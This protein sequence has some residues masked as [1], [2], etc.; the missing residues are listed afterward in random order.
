LAG[1]CLV[2]AIGLACASGA[3]AAGLADGVWTIR[4]EA[5]L[6]LQSATSRPAS[7]L[8]RLPMELTV[9]VR[10]GKAE[11]QAWGWCEDMPALEHPGRAL[12]AAGDQEKA[13]FEVDLTVRHG[14]FDGFFI[15]GSAR[16]AIELAR[17]GEGWTGRYGLIASDSNNPQTIRGLER[18]YGMGIDPQARGE[19]R[20]RDTMARR[21]TWFLPGGQV[22]GKAIGAVGPLPRRDPG[23]KPPN[24]R[25]HP[26]LFFTKRDVPALRAKAAA[27]QAQPIVVALRE[28]SRKAVER[29]F[30]RDGV[31]GNM[32]AV[33]AAGEGLLFQLTG[34]PIHAQR[35]QEWCLSAMYRVYPDGQGWAHSYS[36][37]GMA[38]AY[39]LCY[40]AWPQEFRDRAYAWLWENATSF[41]AQVDDIDPLQTDRYGFGNDSRSAGVKNSYG[42]SGVFDARG[43]RY[44]AAG[45]L[46]ALAISG[47]PPPI[48]RPIPLDQVAAIAPDRDFMPVPGTPVVPFTS[49]RMSELWLMNGPFRRGLA[50]DPLAS[51]GGCASARP[52]E[53]TKVMHD[54]VAVEF[55]T[56]HPAGTDCC[57]AD[58]PRAGLY[59]RE[60][61]GYWYR[62][63]HPGEALRGKWNAAGGPYETDLTL[64]TILDNDQPRVVMAKPNWNY[65]GTGSR[66]WING[67]E[68]TDG[69]VLRL[70]AGM[71]HVM[72]LVRVTG[73]Y[74][75]QA[76][77]LVEYGPA[78]HADAVRRWEWAQRQMGGRPEGEDEMTQVARMLTRSVLRYAERSIG[79]EASGGW[80][81]RSQREF[82]HGYGRSE[83]SIHSSLLP[84]LLA[85]R[86]LT[87]DNLAATGGLSQ[88]APAALRWRG[89]DR[90]HHELLLLSLGLMPREYQPY[91]AWYLQEEGY[92]IRR[93]YEGVVAL[94]GLDPTV[95][96]RHPGERFALGGYCPGHGL[97]LMPSGWDGA[98]GYLVTVEANTLPMGAPAAAGNFAIMGRGREWIERRDRTF[99]PA[100][101]YTTNVAFGG[102]GIPTGG[103]KVVH[104]ELFKNGGGVVS[105]LVDQ[106][107]WGRPTRPR[108]SEGRAPELGG[109]GQDAQVLDGP[110]PKMSILRSVAVD[111]SRRCG[112]PALVVVADRIRGLSADD[113]KVWHLFISHMGHVGD[114][115]FD[116]VAGKRMFRI[117]QGRATERHPLDDIGA[118]FT[119]A[120]PEKA[121]LSWFNPRV[122]GG[123]QPIVHFW[124]DRKLDRL[125]RDR[126]DQLADPA[127]P[128]AKAVKPPAPGAKERRSD[129]MDALIEDGARRDRQAQR[130]DCTYV[131]VFTLGGGTHPK[132][133]VV[134]GASEPTLRVGAR[135]VV[136]SGD[137]LVL[138]E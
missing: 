37:L 18:A 25:E 131:A 134:E 110:P 94:L 31:D 51:I 58:G 138:R 102:E 7:P 33:W 64:Y 93:P 84:L 56:Y 22:E 50:S 23:F 39:D 103:G 72:C 129:D 86:N 9:T 17:Q 123:L 11:A 111:Y 105:V 135:T 73:G 3:G 116:P 81:I 63:Y 92:R 47:D 29:G 113:E 137:K 114:K 87:G 52:V 34:E 125:E 79:P 117:G 126:R 59:P 122:D 98:K 108:P 109:P 100:D 36:V 8:R 62:D 130:G 119:M 10:E 4:L 96:P 77:H 49:G 71:Y 61:G 27:P 15:G 1:G 45:A 101:A 133:E 121:E 19:E 53:G 67:R 124:M 24:P 120:L 90:T 6:P 41:A 26:R 70:S 66:M 106:F 60:C 128:A 38:M 136:L 46:A 30:G 20:Y 74:A 54:G 118:Q 14:R 32:M 42:F 13:T 76:P 89:F 68:V 35:A 115:R 44:R 97:W 78:D 132:V 69:D 75:V 57:G 91:A 43:Q 12:V 80:G 65:T 83:R 40:E 2:L 107:V 85:I 48:P 95:A 28:L 82:K 127:G 5:G 104:H 55:R 88:I 112:M 21:L 99:G 16:Y